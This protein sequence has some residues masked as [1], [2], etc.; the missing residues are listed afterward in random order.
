MP[1]IQLWPATPDDAQHII[2]AIPAEN[3]DL[4]PCT[5]C[6]ALFH[7]PK[8]G[9]G[10]RRSFC[11]KRC[12]HRHAE[13]SPS[14]TRY[15]ASDKGK[16]TRQRKSNKYQQSERG[17]QRYEQRQ[18]WERLV[19]SLDSSQRPQP[20]PN[21]NPWPT[22]NTPDCH[23][24][25]T[26]RGNEQC[27]NCARDARLRASWR[28]A[29]KPC[30]ICGSPLGRYRGKYCGPRCSRK[31]GHK[32]QN[33]RNPAARKAQAQRRR[34]KAW[35]KKLDARASGSYMIPC[36][37]CDEI[38]DAWGLNGRIL[39]FC[40]RRCSQRNQYQTRRSRKRNAFVEVVSVKKLAKWQDWKCHLCGGKIDKT[41]KAPN[42]KSLTLEHLI[43]LSKGGEHSY[44]NCV[45]AHFECN[46]RKSDKAI[47]EQLKLI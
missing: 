47:G 39:K 5:I 28:N 24:I 36:K 15:R 8:S 13:K 31:A 44:R 6:G 10:R 45:A 25:P 26:R 19:I 1:Q 2:N 4:H 33:I 40:S 27:G 9:N 42:P 32:K 30:H 34:A 7:S 16:A 21:L 3:L 43:P 20:K 41:A 35:Q 11:S 14:M 46:W 18:R 29:G 17:R 23:N 38:F 22:C 12:Y 37:S